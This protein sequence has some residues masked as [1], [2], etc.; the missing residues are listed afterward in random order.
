LARFTTTY[1]HGLGRIGEKQSSWFVYYL[2]DALG[3]VRQ[4]WDGGNAKMTL[5]R[6]YE[7]FGNALTSAGSG[8]VSE[9][10]DR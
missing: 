6:S 1:L 2:P 5:A 7:P 10:G 9:I 3:S 8:A 4:L